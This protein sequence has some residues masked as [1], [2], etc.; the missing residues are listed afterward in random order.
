MAEY[1][2]PTCKLDNQE[3]E[4]MFEVRND[5]T[6]IPNNF[7]KQILCL[8]GTKE[9]MIHIYNCK[10]WSEKEKKKTPYNTIYNGNIEEQIE[11]LKIFEQNLEKRNEEMRLSNSH[12]ILYGSTVDPV[13]LG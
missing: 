4:K 12:V 7:G 8:C 11:I 2:Q 10:I 3:K 6:K 9:S 5:M 13:T 1:L